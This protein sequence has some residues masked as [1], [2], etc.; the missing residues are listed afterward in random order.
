MT[1]LNSIT[2]AVEVLRY[3][4]SK[5]MTLTLALL[6]PILKPENKISFIE[7]RG[8]MKYLITL[9]KLSGLGKENILIL[10]FVTIE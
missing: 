8:S 6:M 5:S 4:E 1:G 7:N 9:F 2:S 10:V 3:L